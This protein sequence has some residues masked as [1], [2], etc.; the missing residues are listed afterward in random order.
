[1]VGVA[2]LF[3]YGRCIWIVEYIEKWANVNKE[4]NLRN[5]LAGGGSL[6]CP[7]SNDFEIPSG[8]F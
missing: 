3:G 4:F 5:G 2:F 7:H 8:S 1:M 6:L